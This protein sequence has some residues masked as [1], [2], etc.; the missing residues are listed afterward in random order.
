MPAKE[1]QACININKLLE[2]A[3]WRFFDDG[4]GKANVEPAQAQVDAIGRDFNAT[5]NRKLI[6]RFEVK[7]T[8]T[9]DRVWSAA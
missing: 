7:I 9:I 2:P 4:C 5:S 3:G 6:R 8:T 1:A